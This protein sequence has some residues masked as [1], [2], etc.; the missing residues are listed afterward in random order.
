MANLL[1]IEWDQRE[2]RFVAAKARRRRM[3]VTHAGS[4]PLELRPDE[5]APSADQIG[6]AIRGAVAS[7]SWR[8]SQSLVGIPRSSI[9]LEPLTLPPAPDHELPGLVA[10]QAIIE[11]SSMSEAASLDFDALSDGTQGPRSVLVATIGQ[12]TSEAVRA[13]CAAAAL[14]ATR[15]LVRPYAAASLLLNSARPRAA[16]WMLIVPTGDDVDLTVVVDQHVVFSRGVRLHEVESRDSAA[17]VAE[18]RRTLVAVRNQPPAAEIQAIYVCGD[19]A[20]HAALVAEVGEQLSLPTVVF[21]PFESLALDPAQFG[22][23]SHAKSSYAAL[24]GMLADEA[25]G[26]T[27][28]LDLLNPKRPARVVSE[29]RR[30]IR[31]ASAVLAPVVLLGT[32][33]AFAQFS[34]LNGKIRALS[35]RSRELDQ[36]VKVASQKHAAADEIARWADGQVVWLDELQE[37]SQRFP[38][39]RDAVLLRLAMTQS[40]AGGGFMDMEGLVRDPSIVARIEDRLRDPRHTVHSKRAQE[41]AAQRS[42]TW[43]FE[44]ALAISDQ[45]QS[46]ADAAPSSDPGARRA[47]SRER[48]PSRDA[49]P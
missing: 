35:E 1:A 11:L 33:F 12:K 21:D 18:I 23:A 47:A 20:L 37:L 31:L 7:F 49:S 9:D 22:I 38:R 40:A 44:T 2:L 29:Q 36:L 13:V 25:A 16:C 42:Y 3:Q 17:L 19:G 28:P 34:A 45:P 39:A 43:R 32:W 30:R 4:A 46:P 24:L 10:H 8:V 26:K 41:N 27:P 14:R 6:A 5:N 15:W 48:K